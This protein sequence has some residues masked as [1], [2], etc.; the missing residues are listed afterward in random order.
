ML[1]DWPSRGLIHRPT[2][3]TGSVARRRYE[4][5]DLLPTRLYARRNQRPAPIPVLAKIVSKN[6]SNQWIR[7]AVLSSVAETADRLFVELIADA[8]FADSKEGIVVD[9]AGADQLALAVDR[10]RSRTSWKRSA[11]K[12]GEKDWEVYRKQL[13]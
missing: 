4:P 12:R 6:A 10:R 13:C 8:K 2:S 5:A 7:A 11:D 3:W 1:S 9:R